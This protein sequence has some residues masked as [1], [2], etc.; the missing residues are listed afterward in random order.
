M[1]FN[2]LPDQSPSVALSGDINQGLIGADT[3]GVINFTGLLSVNKTGTYQIFARVIGFPVNVTSPFFRVRFGARVAM[4][5]APGGQ[6][7]G[8]TGGIA[9]PVMHTAG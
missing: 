4:K 8:S 5:F 2:G 6:P 1:P 3:L 9:L 7:S